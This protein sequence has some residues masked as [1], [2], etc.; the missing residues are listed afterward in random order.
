MPEQE[1]QR[2]ERERNATGLARTSCL[3]PLA[4]EASRHMQHAVLRCLATLAPLP[5]GPDET[6]S[7][8]AGQ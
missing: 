2:R 3:T 4:H 7:V 1:R 8:A 6:R 5:V